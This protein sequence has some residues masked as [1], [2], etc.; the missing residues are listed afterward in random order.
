MLMNTRLFGEIDIEDDKMIYFPDGIVGFSDMK[1]FA[2][3]HDEEVN[4]GIRWL[5]SA[6]EPSFAMPVIDPLIVK[7]DYNPLVED[8]LLKKIGKFEPE[9]I[10][11]LTTMTVPSDVKKMTVNLM[12]PFVIN[13]AERKAVQVIV[14]GYDVKFPVYDILQAA[15]KAGE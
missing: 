11:V 12:A 10:L 7:T 3:I 15:K 6:E 1:N 5:Q 14:E 2:L 13:A 4:G 9:D 8:E